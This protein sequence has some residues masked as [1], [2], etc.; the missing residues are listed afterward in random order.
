MLSAIV[1]HI[2]T[3]LDRLG[4]FSSSKRRARERESCNVTAMCRRVLERSVVVVSVLVLASVGSIGCAKRDAGEAENRSALAPQRPST[5]PRPAPSTARST[6]ACASRLYA[7]FSGPEKAYARYAE[8]INAGQWCEA[9]NTFAPEVRGE[10]VR[11][12]FRG[13][14]L[15]AGTDHPKRESYFDRF[16]HVC[17]RYELACGSPPD[18]RPLAASVLQGSRLSA[19]L[20]EL[21]FVPAPRRS[22]EDMYVEIMTNMAAADA[23]AM[24][25][26]QLPLADVKVDDDRATGKA[27]QRGGVV[28]TL[29]FS[30]AASG[31][32]LAYE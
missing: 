20:N 29:V 4:C 17:A 22:L 1:R 31:W 30:K 32:M 26:F 21:G 7:G 3:I 19:E 8:A 18:P 5:T 13:L 15:L 16:A 24:S 12:N 11:A 14:I 25:Q 10:V 6:P 9:I 28:R 2:S 27:T 23:D